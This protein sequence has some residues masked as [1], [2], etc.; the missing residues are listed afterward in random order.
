MHLLDRFDGVASAFWR[1]RKLKFACKF[2]PK[3]IIHPLPDPHRPI[4]LH[5]GMAAYRTWPRSRPA[6]V[7]AKQ[8]KI[9]HFLNGSDCVFV[10][11]QSHRPATDDAFASPRDLSGLPNLIAAQSTALDD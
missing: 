6:D 3:R 10:L 7:T 8:E 9:H 4:P 5:I 2:F 11:G 1:R